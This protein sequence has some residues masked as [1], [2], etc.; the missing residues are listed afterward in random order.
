MIVA[1][2]FGAT[3]QVHAQALP[4]VAVSLDT[5]TVI[6]GVGVGCTGIGGTK[7]DP[8]WLAY[9]VRLEFANTK[10]EYLIGMIVTLSD[11]KGTPLFTVSCQGPW[12][13]LK[14]PDQKSY[15]VEAR[16]T[17]GGASESTAVKSP[18]KGQTRVV[19]VFPEG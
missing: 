16:P 6:S 2:F 7:N 18:A 9:P 5:E 14:L 15:H 19:L 10:R 12:L 4:P 1:A 11:A 17:A 13:P 3:S 8:K